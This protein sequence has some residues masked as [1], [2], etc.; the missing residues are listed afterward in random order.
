MEDVAIVD[1][2]LCIDCEACVDEC[3]NGSISMD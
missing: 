3:P 1:E 2:E